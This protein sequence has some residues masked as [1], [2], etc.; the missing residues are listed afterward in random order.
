MVNMGTR[1]NVT[2]MPIEEKRIA[3]RV[4]PDLFERLD[5]KRWRA[6]SSFQKI[7]IDLFVQWLEGGEAGILQ[8]KTALPPDAMLEGITAK[9][10][11]LME[12]LANMLRSDSAMKDT[13]RELIIR[14]LGKYME[15][16]GQKKVAVKQRKRA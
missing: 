15:Q 6:R 16:P 14:I 2:V 8:A 5:E 11:L 12:G 9:D 10:I 13:E 3:L 7:G 4:S 1:D